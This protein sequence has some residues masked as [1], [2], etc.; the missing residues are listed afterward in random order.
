MERNKKEKRLVVAGLIYPYTQ[1]QNKVSTWTK[2][3]QEIN[4]CCCVAFVLKEGKHNIE[5][6]QKL[7]NE[8]M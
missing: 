8:T 4:C 1:S 3:L 7:Q 5:T 6:I 2:P